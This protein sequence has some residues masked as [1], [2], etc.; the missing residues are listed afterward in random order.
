MGR[1]SRMN[2][3]NNAQVIGTD[4]EL[5]RPGLKDAVDGLGRVLQPADAIFWTSKGEKLFRVI[6][7]RP[8]MDP[9]VE[10]G[11]VAVDLICFQTVIY[12]GGVPMPNVVRVATEA[13]APPMPISVTGTQAMPQPA[14]PTGAEG[15]LQ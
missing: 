1:D 7:V 8:V 13:E 2:L 5:R 14:P 3:V 11:M 12:K 10:P 15:P 4:G 9:T 6:G